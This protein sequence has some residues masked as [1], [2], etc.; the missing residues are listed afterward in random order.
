MKVLTA[1]IY[2][3]LKKGKII[4]FLSK[5]KSLLLLIYIIVTFLLIYTT[6]LLTYLFMIGLINFI[7]FIELIL[8]LVSLSGTI[9]KLIKDRIKNKLEINLISYVAQYMIYG[10]ISLI[11][12]LLGKFIS[13]AKVV[14]LEDPAKSFFN[15]LKRIIGE[16]YEMRRRVSEALPIL[17]RWRL[18][19]A[20]ELAMILRDDWDDRWK[21]DIRRRVVES[22]PFLLSK[23]PESADFFLSYHDK[24]QIFVAFAIIE[25]I[26]EWLRSDKE[27]LEERLNRFM[28]EAEK[29]YSQD[30]IRGLKVLNDII[31]TI[32]AKKYHEAIEMMENYAKDENLYVRLAV[33]RQIPY[34]F[35]YFKER[36][37]SLMEYFLRPEENKNVRRPIAKENCTRA[38]IEALKNPKLK[39]KAESILWKLVRDSDEVIRIGAFDLIDDLMTVDRKLCQDIV[40][41]VLNNE[42]NEKLQ[43]RARMFKSF[44]N[45]L[46]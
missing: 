42:K 36:A 3:V 45:G 7:T 35:P 12:T 4:N 34:V 21:T 40:N 27:K 5:L 23:K 2:K 1:H 28:S 32:S 25:A 44:L 29:V 38:I 33:A 41:F 24:D 18:D 22:I 14:T 9:I 17:F 8:G 6:A 13:G 39:D 26:Y 37:L 19:E 11:D 30:E 46:T 10:D 15:A 20:E 16:S 31:K 43:R